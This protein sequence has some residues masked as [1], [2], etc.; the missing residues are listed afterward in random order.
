[1]IRFALTTKDGEVINTIPAK[2]LD[3]AVKFFSILKRITPESL[4]NI[5]NVTQFIK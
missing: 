1:M 5:Y 2:D 3:E 4:L